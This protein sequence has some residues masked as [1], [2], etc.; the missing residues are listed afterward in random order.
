MARLGLLAAQLLAVVVAFA[1]TKAAAAAILIQIDKPSQTMTVAVDGQAR[2]RWRVST[3]ATGYQ[4]RSAP[5][6][7]SAWR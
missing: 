5:T 1:P 4:P 2:Y 7:P 3:G 6:L